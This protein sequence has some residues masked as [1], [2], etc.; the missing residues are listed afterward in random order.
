MK[1]LALVAGAVLVAL[2]GCA[3]AADTPTQP[4]QTQPVPVQKGPP[5]TLGTATDAFALCLRALP[6][7]HVVSAEWTTV[8]DLRAWGHGGPVQQRPLSK[9]F[10]GAAPE[11]PAV[12]CWTQEAADSV[13][14]WGV[15]GSDPAERAIGI[16]G[17]TGT[18][19]SGPPVIP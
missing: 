18:I 19:P 3:G 16:V 15:H 6:D 12:W 7:R 13:T 5:P 2:S 1:R 14:A 17:P 11:E 9:A 10:P 4:V 8:G